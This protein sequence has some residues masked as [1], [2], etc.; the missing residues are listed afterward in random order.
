MDGSRLPV[1]RLE[2]RLADLNL[3][4]VTLW[5]GE[6]LESSGC[7]GTHLLF[8]GVHS[9]AGGGRCEM[10]TM[11]GRPIEALVSEPGDAFFPRPSSSMLHVSALSRIC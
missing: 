11:D 7:T 9:T 6:A 2:L 1:P 4:G 8:G 3:T 10:E 5:M